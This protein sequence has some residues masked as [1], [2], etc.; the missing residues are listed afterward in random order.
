MSGFKVIQVLSKGTM[1]FNENTSDL[2]TEVGKTSRKS[3]S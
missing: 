2:A 3:K 1:L